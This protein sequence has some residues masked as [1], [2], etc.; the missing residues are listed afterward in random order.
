[1]LSFCIFCLCAIFSGKR[2]GEGGTCPLC[3][4]PLNLSLK[5][6]WECDDEEILLLTLE[7]KIIIFKILALSKFVSLAQALPI[8]NEITTTI[9]QIQREFLWNSSN[10]II[11]HETI[12]NDFQNEGL[13]NV[14]IPSKISSVT[15]LLRQKTIRPK[16]PWPEIDSNAFY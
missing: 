14:N 4:P 6:F 7:G 15:M 8:P 10:V 3:P 1:M 16:L 12:C 13:K 5:K 11:K 9:Q 2:K